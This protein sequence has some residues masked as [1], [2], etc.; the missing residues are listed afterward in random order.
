[1]STFISITIAQFF[2]PRNPK[3]STNCNFKKKGKTKLEAQGPFI[4]HVITNSK[5]FS[6][7]RR[8]PEWQ[9]SNKGM[10]RWQYISILLWTFGLK[11]DFFKEEALP[12]P[13]C[14]PPWVHSWNEY[15][16][17]TTTSM[18]AFQVKPFVFEALFESFLLCLGYTPG[19][20]W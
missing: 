9:D 2:S 11:E 1:M 15:L 8:Q 18:A 3:N 13:I 20:I 16:A 5:Q 14:A 10:C 17:K 4:A 12:L 7:T 19:R 6:Q